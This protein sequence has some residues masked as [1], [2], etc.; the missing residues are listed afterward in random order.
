MC[1]SANTQASG[2]CPLLQTGIALGSEVL[3]MTPTA[4][5]VKPDYV[6]PS[7]LLSLLGL[8]QVPH[9]PFSVTTLAVSGGTLKAPQSA[10]VWFFFHNILEL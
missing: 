10:F 7:H 9:L 5:A 8:G 3:A 6:W 4:Q 2:A 1:P